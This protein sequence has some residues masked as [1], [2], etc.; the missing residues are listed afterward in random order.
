M[1]AAA[2]LLTVGALALAGCSASGGESVSADEDQTIS[3]MYASNELSPEQIA[4]FEDENPNI[5]VEF[6]E[7]DQTRLNTMLAAG[8]PPDFVRGA[9][10]ANTF[11]KGLATALDDYVAESKVITEDELLPINNNWRWD[12][13]KSGVGSLYGIV[14]DWSP[15]ATIWQNTAL[16]EQAGVEP[17]STTEPVSWDELLD[18]AKELKAGG[19]KHGLGVEWAWGL[20]APMFTMILQQ[21]GTIYNADLTE[22]D[23]TSP[24]AQRAF[25]WFVDYAKADVGPTS[26]NPLPDGSDMNVFGT[27]EMATTMDGFWF[28]GGFTGDEFA[29]LRDTISMAP[30]PTFDERVSP[31]FNGGIGAWI[32]SASKHKDAAWKFMEYFMAGQPAID[33]AKS[34]WGVPSLKSLL[35]YVPSDF[36]YQTQS[37]ETAK[38]EFEFNT[39]LPDSPYIQAQ[40]WIDTID[41]Q[42]QAVIKGEKTTA[43][44]T[45]T[46]E[47]EINKLLAQGKDQL[48]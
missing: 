36:P 7:F 19:A 1:A 44:A 46:V 35:D 28:G 32:P 23:F 17:L 15:D 11:A 5:K 45:Q 14:K 10:S 9:P 25:Q 16:F 30:A 13:K 22:A 2:A 48:G 8:D 42:L 47:D 43:E 39:L 40:A 12:G 37:L 34:G 6:I 38:G 21:G 29:G 31:S 41:A 33:R 26:L 18:V 4:A 24:E 3:V 20:A 27:G